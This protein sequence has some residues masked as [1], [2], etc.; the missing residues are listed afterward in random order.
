VGSPGSPSSFGVTYRAVRT[1]L[2]PTLRAVTRRDW[3]GLEHIPATGGCVVVS[4]H[5]SHFD[6]LPLAEF[7]DAAGRKSSFLGKSELFDVPVLGQLLRSAGQIPVHRESQR[8]GAAVTA[9]RDGVLRGDC[10]VIY[11]EGTITRDADLWPMTGKT[12]LARIWWET[13]CPVIPV[14]MWGPQDMLA[15]YGKLPRPWLRPVMHVK[16]GPAVDFPTADPPDFR[17]MTEVA[18]SAITD[19]LR[20][21]RDRTSSRDNRSSRRE[22]A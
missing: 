9:A 22:G 19:L 2:R 17:A 20:S 15:P 3:T 7:L 5:L 16:A 21:L 14:A 18:M 8:A 13:R 12:G 6:P 11:P 1:I 4:N 10:V